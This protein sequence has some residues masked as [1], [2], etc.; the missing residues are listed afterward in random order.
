M[1]QL[2]EEGS[3]VRASDANTKQGPG[4]QLASWWLILIPV[5]VMGGLLFYI[6]EPLLFPEPL[7][8]EAEVARTVTIEDAK[9]ALRRG[10]FVLG[11]TLAREVLLR[12]L[13]A[14]EAYLIAGEAALRLGDIDAALTY[15]RGVPRTSPEQYLISLWSIGN[16]LLHQGDLRQAERLFREVLEQDPSHRIA[17]ERLAFILGVDGR[18]WE[19][20]PHLF[21]PIRQGFIAIEPLLLL[22]T[23][24][25]RNAEHQEIIAQSRKVN[26][27]DWIPLIGTARIMASERNLDGAE[28]LLHDILEHEPDQIEAH[29][30]M[31][32]II[33]ERGDGERFARWLEQLPPAAD[34]HPGIW[35]VRGT[36][37]QQLG[38]LEGAARCYWES[39]RLNPNHQHAN[40]RL[41]RLLMS[42]GRSD[43]AQPF[44]ERAKLLENYLQVAV[45]L[46][47]R[48]EYEPEVG[49]M[50]KAAEVCEALGRV[51]EA[52]AWYHLILEV[53][54]RNTEA[55]KEQQRLE[56]RRTATMPMILAEA[57]PTNDLD[58]SIL[59]LPEFRLP[60][61]R[62]TLVSDMT[63]PQPRF[64]DVAR[65]VGIDFT[66]NNGDDPDVPGMMLAQ[67]LGGAVAVLDYDLDGWPDIYLAQGTPWP[68]DPEQTEFRDRLFRNMGD[69][70][71]EDVTFQANLGDNRYSQGAAVGD[72][73]ND[74]YPDLLVANLGS[75]RLY[76]NQG[77]G[78]FRDV[79]ESAGI[80]GER[81]ST[82][83]VIADL[84]GNGIPDIY[85][86]N[87]LAGNEPLVTECF[88]KEEKRACPPSNFP[89]E[90][91]RLY[92]SSGDGRFVDVT[93]ECGVVVP[94]GKGLGVVAADFHGDGKLSLYVANDT[95]G[96]FYFVNQAVRRGDPLE[97]RDLALPAGLAFDRDGMAQASMGI[98]IGDGDED[99]MLD[100]FVTHFYMQS[101]TYYRQVATDFFED[102][103]QVMGLREPSMPLL[104]FGTQFIDFE[105]D[106]TLDLVLACGHVDDFRHT[107]QPYMMK[108]QV[109]SNR[110]GGQF[111]ELDGAAIGEY[112]QRELLGRSLALIDWDRDGRQDFAVLHLYEPVSLLANRTEDSGNYL[113][114]HLRGVRCARD[115][116]GAIAYATIGDR[117]IMRQLTAGDGFQCSSQRMIHFG[118]G[119][120]AQVDE[121][122]IRWPSGTQETF[123]GVPVNREVILIEGTQQLIDL[124]RDDSDG[125]S[126]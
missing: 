68:I 112:F 46:Y 37:A 27:N 59:P 62:D 10:D 17:N 9:A 33:V 92:L 47:E 1:A 30:L 65:A 90:Q 102:A 98:A 97:F 38:E 96:N 89:E 66:Y 74:G 76:H 126:E 72:F 12:D 18:R 86:V 114:L 14:A 22:G 6:V 67:E 60:M 19:S 82:S 53:D 94:G 34:N 109:F 113:N 5:A 41:G 3:H 75:N 13:D 88:E 125:S 43:E 11:G 45:P 28:T 35:Y 81:W 55:R 87:Y 118:V 50:M 52:W 44:L 36:W 121:L 101:N 80:Q 110:G 69:G 63:G 40:Y 7:P 8:P 91:D 93:D 95:T 116:I 25:S 29:A 4:K 107:G 20:V 16:V 84:S 54:P 115:A 26:P 61:A 117:S 32:R 83:C 24:D 124:P 71:F 15:Y 104:A 31:G 99:G 119:D 49:Q 51:W 77:D 70:T 122:V 100:L 111:V 42:L 39:A 79:T 57:I 2:G 64:I 120:A 48:R 108:P 56:E 123:T 106:G 105:N 58:L 85:I 23:V 78:T 73:D 21:E 103:T